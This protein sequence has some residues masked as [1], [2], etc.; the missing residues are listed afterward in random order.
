MQF[1][2][3]VAAYVDQHMQDKQQMLHK[4]GKMYEN[5]DETWQHSSANII[6]NV[7]M[8]GAR[9]AS[10]ATNVDVVWTSKCWNNMFHI[11]A[12]A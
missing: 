10:V 9:P 1:P 4:S 2:A 12:Y 5:V 3:S 8:W 6:K 7:Q 11:S